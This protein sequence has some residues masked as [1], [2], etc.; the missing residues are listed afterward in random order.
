MSLKYNIDWLE[1]KSP[2]WKIVSLTNEAGIKYTDVSINKRDKNNIEFP[3]FDN[4]KAGDTI[5]G[6]FW[7]KPD[8]S[9]RYLYPPRIEKP[10]R[11]GSSFGGVSKLMDKKAEQIEKAQERK[12]ESI[13]YFNATNNA[14]AIVNEFSKSAIE[15]GLIYTTSDKQKDIVEWRDWFLSEYERWNQKTPF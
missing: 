14:I 12:S 15:K 6:E 5:S 7:E 2:E 1:E 10:V 11:G 4:L 9:K 8:K 13:A 3:N